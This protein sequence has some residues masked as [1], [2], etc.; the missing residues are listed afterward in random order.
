M[1]AIMSELDPKSSAT[2]TDLW[3][4]LCEECGLQAIYEVSTPHFTW[5]VA[6]DLD[7]PLTTS[8]LEDLAE[9]THP[10]TIHTFGLGIFSGKHPILYLPMVKSVEMIN[11]H[12]RIWEAMEPLSKDP[13]MYYSPKLWVPHITLALNDLSE[14]NLACAMNAVAFEPIELFVLVN[15]VALAEHVDDGSGRILSR[16]NFSED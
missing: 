9:E 3:H 11:F 13:K 6:D 4:K 10:L 5:F 12:D 15:N 16:S 2:V 14:A 7:V 8:V 1:Y